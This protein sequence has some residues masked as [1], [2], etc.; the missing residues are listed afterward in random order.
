LK[1]LSASLSVSSFLKETLQTGL[2]GCGLELR[3]LQRQNRL[4]PL[5]ED[6][7]TALHA[8][9]GDKPSSFK[10][11]LGK[12]VDFAGF[13]FGKDQWHPFVE[14]LQIQE[15]SGDAAAGQFLARFYSIHQPQSAAEAFL[16]F[17]DAPTA[18]HDLPPHLFYLSPWTA[19]SAEELAAVIE[20]WTH[21]DNAE[22]G[23]KTLD[24]ATGGF[25]M[26]GPVSDEKR[27]LEFDRLRRIKDSIKENG[28][29]RRCGDSSFRVLKRGDD[30]RFI[31]NGGGY[32]RVAAMAASGFDWIPGRIFPAPFVID[33]AEVDY[34]PQVRFGF[35]SKNQALA[36][37]DY[38]FDYNSKAWRS[39]RDELLFV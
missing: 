34:W 15:E 23:Q 20:R 14:M 2:A 5:C 4:R 16:D 6:F 22:H 33:C 35:W 26:F 3:R 9:R 13:G 36:Y 39:Y 28:Y 37:V 18:L 30:F 25:Q 11:P 27:R 7:L 10:C 12:V 1:P 8:S 17:T 38:L 24:L 29:D 21:R 32:H 19:R 31:A